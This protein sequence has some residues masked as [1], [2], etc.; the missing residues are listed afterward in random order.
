LRHFRSNSLTLNKE[1]LPDVISTR[2]APLIL[3]LA[4]L[5]APVC[6]VPPMIVPSLTAPASS[7]NFE[8]QTFAP[9]LA[10][11]LSLKP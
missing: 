1:L 8:P 2:K 9:C 3:P 4:A 10:D 5:T 6:V 11:T 7:T